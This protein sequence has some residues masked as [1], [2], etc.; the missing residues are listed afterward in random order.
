MA[1]GLKDKGEEYFNKVVFGGL[2]PAIS[3]AIGLFNDSVDSL[4]DS[5]D[6]VN[7]TTEPSG[8]SYSRQ[9]VNVPAEVTISSFEGNW[10]SVFR[11]VTFN[12]SD[13]SG[14]VDA[15]FGIVKF[16]AQGDGVET[17]HLLFSGLLGQAYDLQYVNELRVEDCRLSID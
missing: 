16:Q 10:R 11:D 6:V 1:A 4:D 7:I 5:A 14:I 12:T 13:S 8:V 9:V 2:S 17:D 15:Y 3:I